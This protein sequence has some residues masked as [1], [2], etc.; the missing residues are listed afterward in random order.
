LCCWCCTLVTAL[1]LLLL[2]LLLV[3]FTQQL[4]HMHLVQLIL[5]QDCAPPHTV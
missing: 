3:Y 5:L 4:G 2:L 1:L